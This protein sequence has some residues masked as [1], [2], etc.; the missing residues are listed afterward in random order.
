MAVTRVPH[1]DVLDY[2]LNKLYLNICEIKSGLGN[3]KVNLLGTHFLAYY[4]SNTS[5]LA[6]NYTNDFI[7]ERI[8]K[9]KE[10]EQ[11]VGP[12][13]MPNELIKSLSSLDKIHA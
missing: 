3:I 9:S 2:L 7:F 5:S 13:K 1:S 8:I 4:L 12:F 6:K 10:T 11:K